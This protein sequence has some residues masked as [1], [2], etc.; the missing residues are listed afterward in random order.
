PVQGTNGHGDRPQVRRVDL[1][2]GEIIGPGG[3]PDADANPTTRVVA[4][5]GPGDWHRRGDAYVIRYRLRDVSSDRYARVRGT[6]TDEE[7]PRLD[8]GEDPWTDLWFYSNPVFIHARE[9]GPIGSGGGTRIPRT[10]RAP[11]VACGDGAAPQPGH[12]R[13]LGRGPGPEFL[14]AARL[15]GLRG[16]AD[17]VLPSRWYRCGVVG[18]R[19]ARRRRGYRRPRRRRLRRHRAGPQRAV[20]RGGRRG[21]GRGGGRGGRH[22]PAGAGDVLRRV[23]RVLHRPGRPCLGDRLQPRLPARA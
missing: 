2:V 11:A 23:R 1:I 19:Q 6:N 22:H 3:D 17:G 10:G 15:A 5:F 16:R 18:P 21:A 7:E 12:A 8:A 13:S 20:T 4:R 14:R 9:A